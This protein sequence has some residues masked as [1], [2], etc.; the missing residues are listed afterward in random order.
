MKKIISLIVPLVLIFAFNACGSSDKGNSEAIPI[1][2]C[3]VP[4]VISS[5]QILYSGDIIVDESNTSII[6]TYHDSD[7]L[8]RICL[9]SGQASILRAKE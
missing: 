2:A 6:T 8:K 5:Y 9:N 7:N 3:I 1:E 4:P